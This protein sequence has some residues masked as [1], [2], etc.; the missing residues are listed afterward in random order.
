VGL[1]GQTGSGKTT[2]VDI[3]LGLLEP[4]EGSLLVDGTPIGQHNVRAWQRC[5]GHVPQEIFLVDDTVVANIAFGISPAEVDMAAVERAA[6]IANLHG[7]V[8][9]ELEA[10]Y[11]TLLGERGVRLSGG[12]R[13]RVGIAR[14]LYRDPEVLV[15]DEATSA[16]DNITER[17]VIDAVGTL[18]REKT[19]IMVA[20]RLSTVR[21]C[22]LIYL[23]ERGRVAALGSYDELMRRS[24]HFKTMVSVG[25]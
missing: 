3:L 12:Q 7:F 17:A 6:R 13:Q 14:A 5:I 1:V 8:T 22:D 21:Q 23:L 11:Q 10:G 25:S 18:E 15:F 2:L 16:L 9:D 4:V 20:H 19:I 24:A